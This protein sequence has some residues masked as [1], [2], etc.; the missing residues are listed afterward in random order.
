M[1]LATY[2]C[3]CGAEIRYK[4]DMIRE[5]GTVYARW[6]CKYCHTSVPATVAEKIK[7]QH[8]S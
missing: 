7:H 4:Q 1:A 8:P 5:Q 6:K 2:T 3:T